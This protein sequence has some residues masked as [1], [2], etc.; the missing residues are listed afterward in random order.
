MGNLA[1]LI[2]RKQ[3]PRSQRQ[4]RDEPDTG[5]DEQKAIRARHYSR[6]PAAPYSRSACFGGKLP[7]TNRGSQVAFATAA[8]Q[9]MHGNVQKNIPASGLDRQDHGLGIRRAFQPFIAGV[10]FRAGTP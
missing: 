2:P 6:Q 7:S 4:K 3:Q 8:R 10:N 1:L 9:M 5:Q